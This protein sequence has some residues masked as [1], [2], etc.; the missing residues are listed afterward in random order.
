MPTAAF[1]QHR[2]PR[3]Y[4]LS[5]W[6]DRV[7]GFGLYLTAL[8]LFLAPAGVSAGLALLWLGFFLA[9]AT[10]R[11][12][13]MSVGVLLALVF[14]LYALFNGVLADNPGSDLGGRLASA[15]DWAQLCVFV[16]VA[17]ALRGDQR[18]LIHLLALALFGLLLGGLWRLDWALLLSD[19]AS[20]LGSRPGFGFPA[21]VFALFS[22]I[23]LIGLFVFRVR[24]WSASVLGLGGWWVLLWLVAVAL[25]LQGFVVTLSRG[26]WI[27][28]ACTVIVA[29]LMS[30]RGYFA[31]RSDE[32][33][34]E[35]PGE[36]LGDGPGASA[37]EGRMRRLRPALPWLGVLLLTGLLALNAGT[38]IDRLGA[39][40]DAASAILSG[41]SDFSAESSI[42]LRWHAQRFGLSLWLE[43]PVFGWGPGSTHALI[44]SSAEPALGVG[45]DEVMDHLH[46]TYLELLVQLGLIGLVIWLGLFVSL[47]LSIRKAWRG[48][49]LSA[50]LALFLTL[51]IVYL[52]AWNL[53]DFHALHQGWRGLWALLAGSALS[54]GLYAAVN[55]EHAGNAAGEHGATACASP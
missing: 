14:G 15:A 23:A 51:A 50:D 19:S 2:H 13:P 45:G 39:E 26:A 9:L 11:R 53:F 5:A 10:G 32:I 27:A 8:S 21:I 37:A 29:V 33:A 18:R 30:R 3:K 6:T 35:T 40:T 17:Y 42:G 52:S 20:F 46:N 4:T 41:D 22:G 34:G 44:A 38:I 25:L 7:Q 49:L 55:A 54:V 47:F 28:L 1:F 24:W 31:A 43:R 36:R 16:P 48:Q 12:L